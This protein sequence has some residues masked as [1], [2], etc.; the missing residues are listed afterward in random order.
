MDICGLELVTLFVQSCNEIGLSLELRGIGDFRGEHL[1]QPLSDGMRFSWSD[2]P[3]TSSSNLT[4]WLGLVCFRLGPP[5]NA[6]CCPLTC[7]Q[8]TLV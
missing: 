2:K 4:A 1:D 8:T 5:E 6:L 7:S 3:T